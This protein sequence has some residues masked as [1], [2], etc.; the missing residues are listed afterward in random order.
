[1]TYTEVK[2]R[3]GKRYFYRVRSIRNGRKFRKERIYLGVNLSGGSLSE[4]EARADKKLLKEGSL[5]I[6]LMDIPPGTY[7]I[8]VLDDE[9]S[10]DRMKYNLLRMPQEGYGF[11]NNIKPVL[12]C[13]P[14]E[15]CT[16]R[17]GKGHTRLEIEIQYFREQS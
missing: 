14:Y 11:S 17:V 1:M 10:N 9:D 5:R 15:K 12:K 4:K 2:E 3:A 16:F 6:T 7:A 8:T 13:P